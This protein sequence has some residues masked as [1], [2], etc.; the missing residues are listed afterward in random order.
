MFQNFVLVGAAA[1]VLAA[2]Q[3]PDNSKTNRRDERRQA[4]T[5]EEQSNRKEDIELARKIRAEI[6]SHG[7]FST[8]AKNVKVITQDGVAV[9]RGPVR[10]TEEKL[11]IEEIAQKHAG[12][13]KVKSHLEVAPE[14]GDR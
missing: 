2:A 5:A 1:L 12:A 9:L 8:Y 11:A 3:A 13:E 6:S 10:T 14:K 7:E 4:V